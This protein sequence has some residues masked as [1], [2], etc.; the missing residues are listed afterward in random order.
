MLESALVRRLL[1]QL[2]AAPGV[3][4]IKIHG[5]AFTRNGEPDII[6][7]VAV[8]A[9]P[10]EDGYGQ[11]FVIE[12]KVQGNK[13]TLLQ[14]RRLEEWRKVNAVAVTADEMFSVREF[15]ASFKEI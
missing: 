5:N 6:G 7:C 15:L 4:A 13:P 9:T 3:K 8:H 12:C 14:M 2:N 11:M 10:D 1:R